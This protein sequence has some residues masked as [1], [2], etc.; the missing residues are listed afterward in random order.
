MKFK[1][2]KFLSIVFF[3]CL[4]YYLF[5]S[6]MGWYG[7]KPW[8][9]RRNTQ[10]NIIE[11][12]QRKVFVKNLKFIKEKEDTIPFYIYIE[13][14]YRCGIH[15]IHK[16]RIINNSE[17]PFQLSKTSR[18]DYNNYHLS[19]EVRTISS[20]DT[21]YPYLKE[22]VIKDT[23]RVIVKKFDEQSGK[24]KIINNIKVWDNSKN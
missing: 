10:G 2:V 22:A 7:H 12:K 24:W 3:L 18:L 16:T 5:N 13:K 4:I 1:F 19:F 14:G 17:Y 8:L 9:L 6:Y 15:S 23:I 11:S 21:I 20:F